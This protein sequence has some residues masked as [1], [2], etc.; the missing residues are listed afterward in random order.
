MRNIKDQLY[1]QIFENK[2]YKNKG[3]KLKINFKIIRN[4]CIKTKVNKRGKL[5]K[6]SLKA[7]SNT[8]LN[9]YIIHISQNTS[10]V[11]SVSSEI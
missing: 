9:W 10:P 8:Y 6:L 7:K 3:W 4:T 2:C 1:A 11:T 5:P